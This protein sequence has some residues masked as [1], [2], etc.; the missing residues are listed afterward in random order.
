MGYY[1]YQVPGGEFVVRGE[2]YWQITFNGVQI[3]GLYRAP[4]EA[5]EAVGRRREAC[6]PGPNLHGVPNPPMDLAAWTTPA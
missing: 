2:H 3:G 4:H 5:L 6:I 1:R